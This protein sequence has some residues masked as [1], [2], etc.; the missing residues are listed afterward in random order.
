LLILTQKIA[1]AG[2]VPST[3]SPLSAAWAKPQIDNVNMI[4]ASVIEIM[5]LNIVLPP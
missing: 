4:A 3:A 5:C 1:L 2:I